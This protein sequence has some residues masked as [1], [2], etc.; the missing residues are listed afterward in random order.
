MRSSQHPQSKRHL[1]SQRQAGKAAFLVGAWYQQSPWLKS[2]RPLSCVFQSLAKKRR[3]DFLSGKKV[4]AKLSVPVIIVGN[5]TVGGTGKTPLVIALVAFLKSQ[6][7][8]PG[9]VSRGYTSKAPYY[10]Y[11]VTKE[12]D[13]KHSGDEPL[14]IA[15]SC[16]CPVV[17]DPNR[18]NAAKKL[19][20][21]YDCDIIVSD[22]G[23]QHYKLG[24]QLEICVIDGQRGLGNKKCLPEGPLREPVQRLSGVDFVVV[25]GESSEVYAHSQF[26]MRL[27]PGALQPL[28]DNIQQ[29]PPL[30]GEKVNA[31]AGI[32]NPERFFDL[33]KSSEYIVSAYPFGDHYHYRQEDFIF[34]NSDAILMT[35]KDAVKCSKFGLT[36]AWYLPVE[37]Q[38]PDAFWQQLLAVIKKNKSPKDEN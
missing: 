14:L 12:S 11:A 18:V 8:Q 28:G 26:T 38:L 3:S 7:Y 1:P 29:T 9:V 15:T 2:L 5:I 27:A 36:N 35:E 4:V 10:P 33:L 22:D 17:I 21:D 34:S 13:P 25:N 37:A 24:R 16:Q 6:G 23:L 30:S 32:G 31:I 19:I 20:D